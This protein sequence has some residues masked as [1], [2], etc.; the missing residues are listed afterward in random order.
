MFL[1]LS[2][3]F[4]IGTYEYTAVA[5]ASFMAHAAAAAVILL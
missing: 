5:E 3:A 1:D 4:Y 2:T